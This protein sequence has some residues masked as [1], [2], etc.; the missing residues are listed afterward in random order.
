MDGHADAVITTAT[1]MKFKLDKNTLNIESDPLHHG[2]WTLS[3]DRGALPTEFRG[4]YTKRTEA[5]KAAQSYIN[6][7]SQSKE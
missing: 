5:L 3:L 6:S 4:R 1:K 7:R 2:F